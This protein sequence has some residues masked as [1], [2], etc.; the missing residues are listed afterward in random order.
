MKAEWLCPLK[1]DWW[2]RKMQVWKHTLMRQDWVE[3]S[4]H[5]PSTEA[6]IKRGA[7]VVQKRE[8]LAS[9]GARFVMLILL[10]WGPECVFCELGVF[11]GLAKKMCCL[12]LRHESVMLSPRFTA[13][14][15]LFGKNNNTGTYL[16]RRGYFLVATQS[17]ELINASCF[18]KIEPCDVAI[19]GGVSSQKKEQ[20]SGL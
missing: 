12:A 20:K 10:K 17:E 2:T 7:R 4:G 11:D 9:V 3:M 1:V 19:E 8:R 15:G 6:I 14:N 13:G 18:L 16:D 5:F